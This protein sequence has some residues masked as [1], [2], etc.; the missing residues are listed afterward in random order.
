MSQLFKS[1]TSVKKVFSD[2]STPISLYATL[3]EKFPETILLE[4]SD[5]IPD[6]NCYSYI[7]VNPISFFKLKNDILEIKYP[8]NSTVNENLSSKQAALSKLEAYFNSFQAP[9][10]KEYNHLANGLFGFISFDAIEYFDTIKLKPAQSEEIPQIYYRVYEFVIALNHHKKEMFILQNNF[11]KET[12]LNI[13]IED[14]E[15]ILNKEEYNFKTFQTREEEYSNMN[16]EEHLGMIKNCQKHIKR[17]DVFQIVPARK[18]MQK[19]E[20]DDF[21]VYRALR[22]INPSPY[23]FYFNF[24]DFNIFG[25]SP[26]ADLL[27]ENRKAIIHPIAGTAPRV[28]DE[29]ENQKIIDELLNDPKENSEHIMLVDLARNDLSKNCKDVLVESY[30]EVQKFSHVNHLVSIVSGKMFEH[31]TSIQLL[32][33]TFPAGTLS[34]APKYRAIELISN[35]EP[36]RRESYGGAIGF[37]NFNGDLVHAIMIRT[38]LS[39]NNILIRQ[40][41]GGVVMDSIPEKEVEEV[42][43]KLMAL[44]KALKLAEEV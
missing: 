41:G 28:Q 25:S 43:N 22:K 2:I 21:Q 4:A 1:I 11:A 24:P 19:F 33:D 30:R 12:S 9:L 23:L 35:F 38:F 27:I 36:S 10:E 31:T 26:E 15:N 8:D 7:A 34:G 39:K 37:I 42:N 40:A 16:T 32:A 44:K 29:T 6:V 18:F 17:G 13:S 3:R 5:Y 20:G 14:L